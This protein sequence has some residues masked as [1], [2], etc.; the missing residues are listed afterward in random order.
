MVFV[1]GKMGMV[2]THQWF[3]LVGRWYGINPS[4]VFVGGKMGMVSTHQLCLL[5]MVV[6]LYLQ[7]TFNGLFQSWYEDR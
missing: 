5:S 7:E 2:S 3:L 1:G 4:M 6:Y